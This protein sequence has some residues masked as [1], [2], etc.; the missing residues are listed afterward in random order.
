MQIEIFGIDIP[1]FTHYFGP[2]TTGQKMARVAD[3]LIEK[4]KTE[5]HQGILRP[6]DQ[7]EESALAERFG[8]SRTPVRE[9]VRSLVESGLLETRSRKGAFVRILSAKELMDL[10]EVAAELE[11]MACRLASKRCTAQSASRIQAGFQACLAASE[12]EDTE[13]YGLANLQFHLAIHTAS[14]NS[15]LVEQLEQI[16]AHV[17]PYRS[18]PYKLRGRLA[19][20]VEEHRAILDSI[21][22]GEGDHADELMRDHMMLQGQRLPILLQGL[23]EQN[24]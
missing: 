1:T 22:A 23:G 6:G 7:L 16:E 2:D 3:Q 14:G 21:L 12:A 4:L 8:V 24:R 5:I 11:G 10:F 15:R 13:A 19:Q 20:S 9:A 18:M 17:N